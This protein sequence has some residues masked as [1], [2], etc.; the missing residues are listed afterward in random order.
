MLAPVS[1]PI[2]R[3]YT[4]EYVEGDRLFVDG[5]GQLELI[6]TQ[7]MLAPLLPD[8]PSR[9]ADIGGG[10]GV[11]AGWLIGLG[12]EVE[13]LDLTPSHVAAA[14]EAYPGL[15]THV[16]DARVLPWGDATFDVT[17]VM[18]PIYHLIGPADRELALSEAL[19]VTRPG[20]VVAVTAISRHASILD[21]AVFDMLND[22]TLA[23]LQQLLDTGVNDGQF[24]FTEAYMH[25]AD[26]FE[27]ELRRSGLSD[28]SVRGIEG[29]VW[30]V[31]RFRD[32]KADLKP[33]LEAARIS[34]SDPHV[35]AAS[36]HLLGVGRKLG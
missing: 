34:E 25:T 30:P 10:T 16:G 17:L 27:A 26:E 33:F 36:A 2:I 35:I 6:R 1:N 20:G 21:L 32:P 15:V 11:Y 31:T 23:P 29:P 8:A 9:I 5:A 12:H 28:I 19:R 14:A 4:D 22:E 13:L 3:Y 7:E 24:G 18:G